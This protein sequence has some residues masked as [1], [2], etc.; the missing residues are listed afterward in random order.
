MATKKEAKDLKPGDEFWWDKKNVGKS[1]PC[2]LLEPDEHG[3]NSYKD[4][5]LT[6][7]WHIGFEREVWVK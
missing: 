3:N 1:K 4:P 2:I 6:G 5:V 7:E